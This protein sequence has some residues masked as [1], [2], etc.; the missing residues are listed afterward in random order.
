MSFERRLAFRAGILLLALLVFG[1]AFYFL[2]GNILEQG[3][4]LAA[5]RELSTR[6]TQLLALL[7]DLKRNSAGLDAYQKQIDA[8]VPA[9]DQLVK[10]SRALDGVARAD[11]VGME[12]VFEGASNPSSPERLGYNGFRLSAQGSYGNVLNFLQFLELRSSQFLL[13]LDDFDLSQNGGSYQVV[14]HGK[15]FFR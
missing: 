1:A 11:Q 4:S 12:F 14:A 9:K 8:L 3:K 15:V 7:A 13:A 5:T 2:T 6:R 10:V